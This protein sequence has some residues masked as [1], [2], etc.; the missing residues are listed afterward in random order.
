VEYSNFGVGDT[1]FGGTPTG[2]PPQPVGSVLGLNRQ[3][4]GDERPTLPKR[5]D[6]VISVTP[7]RVKSDTLTLTAEWSLPSTP[8]V[9]P[10][11]VPTV[12]YTPQTQSGGSSRT[13]P[14]YTSLFSGVSGLLYKSG[15]NHSWRDPHE[16][17]VQ[18]TG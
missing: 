18:P 16:T 7:T 5:D 14:S 13:R 9:A 8:A 15:D 6:G 10:A 11:P 3:R 17:T 4:K 1:S 2:V 12:S